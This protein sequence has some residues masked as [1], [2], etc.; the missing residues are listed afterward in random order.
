MQLLL[1][2]IVFE[3][4][5]NNMKSSFVTLLLLFFCIVLNAQDSL[6][7]KYNRSFFLG[8]GG[9][10]L[11]GS[12][13]YQQKIGKTN[14]ASGLFFRAGTGGT[15]SDGGEFCFSFPVGLH[16]KF[17]KLPKLEVGAGVVP[18]IFTNGQTSI[19]GF[20][21]LGFYPFRHYA[22]RLVFSPVFLDKSM[23]SKNFGKQSFVRFNGGI[24]LM[25]FPLKR[26]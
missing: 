9:P 18:H 19:G 7:A 8:F 10:G 17:V 4:N 26:K 1:F 22:L 11:G 5:I 13:N 20:T 3:H 14:Q 21:L 25:L 23:N 12:I 6:H 2:Q 24:E 16:Y 15:D